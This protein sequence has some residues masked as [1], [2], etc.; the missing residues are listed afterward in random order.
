MRTAGFVARVDGSVY[1]SVRASAIV[2]MTNDFPDPAVPTTVRRSGCGRAPRALILRLFF[3]CEI[4]GSDSNA[5]LASSYFSWKLLFLYASSHIT[6]TCSSTF[7]IT[8]SKISFWPG[9]MPSSASAC[10]S[11]FTCRSSVSTPSSGSSST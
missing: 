7:F 8:R 6:P 4:D 5:A 3:P 11:S 10:A 2:L 9:F 1:L